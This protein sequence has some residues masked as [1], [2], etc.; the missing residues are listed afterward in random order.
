MSAPRRILKNMTSLYVAEIARQGANLLTFIYLARTIN[1]EGYGVV[2]WAK[3]I[4]AYFILAVSLGF[5]V[6]GVREIAKNPD[7][8]EKYVNA[9][10]SI[11]F[12]L[13][14]ASYIVLGVIVLLMNKPDYVKWIV[15]IAGVNIFS[16]A[17]L[18]NWVFQ[19]ME[20]MGVVALR[21]FLMSFFWL[22]GMVAFVRDEND[23]LIAMAVLAGS[24]AL[25]SAWMI[26]YYVKNYS[27]LRFDFDW[28]FWKKLTKASVAIGMTYFLVTIYQNFGITMLGAY[29]GDFETGIY[30][31]AFNVLIFS[32]VPLSVIQTSFFPN[33]SAKNEKNAIVRVMEKYSLISYLAGVFIA[34]FIYFYA[35]FL[36]VILGEKYLTSVHILKILMF[37]TFLA[38]A[39]VALSTP[40]MAQGK[41]KSV[42]FV[43]LLGGAFNLAVNFFVV[44]EYGAPGAA[45]VSVAT[46]F[47]VFIGCAFLVY[48]ML[49]RIFIL[50]YLKAT[51]I[52]VFVCGGG[53]YLTTVGASEY[54]CA[55]ASIISYIL[56]IFGTKMITVSE[57]KKY[58]KK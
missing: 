56:L 18:M 22:V 10:L 39:V 54:L 26:L 13:A 27:P 19:G 42:M 57:L 11:R 49:K 25:N 33:I 46:E 24:L 5:D 30:S 36:V 28:Q 17:L 40:L 44:P 32:I 50:N 43:V 58:L 29:R 52:C 23:A 9:I 1:P 16:N 3:S 37:N 47:I 20:K 38:T 12:S 45:Y 55:G 51:A 14:V 31:A 7:R 6:L 8:R 15:M 2:Q 35:D 4:V 48:K 53:Y 41:E 34:A 21:Q